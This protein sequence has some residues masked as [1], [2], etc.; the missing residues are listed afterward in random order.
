VAQ[1]RPFTG[2]AVYSERYEMTILWGGG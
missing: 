2:L 1:D